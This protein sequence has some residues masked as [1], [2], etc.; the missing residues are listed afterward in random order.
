MRKARLHRASAAEAAEELKQF[1]TGEK[2]V[3][4]PLELKCAS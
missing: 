4:F 1:E 3:S 2:V